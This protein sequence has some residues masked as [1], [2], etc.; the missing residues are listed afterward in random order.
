MNR[1]FTEDERRAIA[2]GWRQ[3]GL[4]QARYSELQGISERTLRDWLRKYAPLRCLDPERAREIVFHA[5]G[6]L[7]ALLARLDAG[8]EGA[9]TPEAPAPARLGTPTAVPEPAPC[10]GALPCASSPEQEA[11]ERVRRRNS[12]GF[13]WNFD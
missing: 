1:S 5:I 2:E 8:L 13:N 3:S 10:S 4:T 12:T 7:Q 11:A 6:E 9:V